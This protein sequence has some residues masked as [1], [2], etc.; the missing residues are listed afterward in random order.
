MEKIDEDKR[1][2]M[3]TLF[4]H[5]VPRS[6]LNATELIKGNQEV[7]LRIARFVAFKVGSHREDFRWS[8]RE[9]K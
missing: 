6:Q 5:I 1:E 2:S 8:S 3:T 9:R 4:D 7:W